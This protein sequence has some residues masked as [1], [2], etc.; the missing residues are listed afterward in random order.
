MSGFFYCVGCLLSSVMR[1]YRQEKKENFSTT[2]LISWT[3]VRRML[4]K[5]VAHRLCSP[6]CHRVYIVVL[7]RS[8][9]SSLLFRFFIFMF[10]IFMIFIVSFKPDYLLNMSLN[11][12]NSVLNLLLFR[13]FP[14]FGLNTLCLP[15]L[16]PVLNILNMSQSYLDQEN[17]QLR[18]VTQYLLSYRLLSD[19]DKHVQMSYFLWTIS[20][21]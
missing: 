1:A 2:C 3:T 4:S 8:C 6:N 21:A 13:L 12:L 18:E 20:C 7:F 15:W 17:C 9:S 10:S 16:S 11:L 5:V 14:D 19:H